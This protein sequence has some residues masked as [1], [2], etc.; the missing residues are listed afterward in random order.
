MAYFLGPETRRA[1][2]TTTARWLP[3]TSI[4]EVEPIT[5]ERAG[6]GPWAE[7]YNVMVARLL[8]PINVLIEENDRIVREARNVDAY[9]TL[10]TLTLSKVGTSVKQTNAERAVVN[11]VNADIVPKL[12]AFVNAYN[13]VITDVKVKPLT[14][15]GARFISLVEAKPT[16]DVPVIRVELTKVSTLPLPGRSRLIP[17]FPNRTF[18]MS[19][20]NKDTEDTELSG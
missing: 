8:E 5:F 9:G 2:L 10:K 12:E 6:S 3:L 11:H 15:I 19:N 14:G 17:M 16:F 20:R 13:K 18:Y 7:Y 1:L 4:K